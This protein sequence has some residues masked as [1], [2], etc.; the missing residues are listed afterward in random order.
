ML[1][2][3]VMVRFYGMKTER[4]INN[5]GSETA[6]TWKA[7]KRPNG[8][9]DY[10]EQPDENTYEK[11]QKAGEGYDLASAIARLE[12]GDTSIKA[13]SMVY[14]EGTDLENLPKDIMTM[15]EKA[16]A[17]A[18]TMKQLKQVQQTEQPKPEEEEKKEEVKK[19]EQKQ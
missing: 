10:I 12:A 13:K 15:H 2:P 8:T 14:T 18:E 1:N 6:P 11:I 7:V 19:D 16:E 17:A 4:A 9:T 3:E 5:P